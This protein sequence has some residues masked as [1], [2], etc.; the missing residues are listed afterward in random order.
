[1]DPWEQLSFAGPEDMRRATGGA[2]A[3]GDQGCSPDN[4]QPSDFPTRFVF[5]AAWRNLD[6][7]VRKGV[8]PPRAPLLQLKPAVTSAS[9]RPDDAF[10][11]DESGNAK[12]GVRSPAIDV[13]AA[14]W[15]GAKTGGFR[16]LFAGYKI[17]FDGA[18]LR[19][20]YGDHES[21]VAKV[22]ASVVALREAGWLT[23]TDSAAIVREAEMSHVP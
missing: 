14:R 4:V 19:S 23:P 12:G 11:V 17:P 3:A 15:V 2:P 16:C 7:W 8:P 18:R 6:Q 21:Y 13:P 10:V 20:L 1:M 22:R 5:N 9:F